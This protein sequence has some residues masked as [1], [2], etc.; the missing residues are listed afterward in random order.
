MSYRRKEMKNF[1]KERVIY[2]FLLVML[3]TLPLKT[4]SVVAQTSEQ[5]SSTEKTTTSIQN[6]NSII[7]NSD[8]EPTNSMESSAK[9]GADSSETELSIHQ[10]K[11]IQLK[12]NQELTSEMIED[13]VTI[14][15][16]LKDSTLEFLPEETLF[17]TTG[18][19]TV[20]IKIIEKYGEEENEIES[21][22]TISVE[23][24]P[25]IIAE[26]NPQDLI[27]GSD[28]SMWDISDFV[29]WVRIDG[30]E[31][32]KN[33]YIVDLVNIPQTD[34]VYK[35][36]IKVKVSDKSRARTILVDVPINIVWG[37][38]IVYQT[39]TTVYEA[40]RTAGA[41]TL[42]TLGKPVVT[43]AIGVTGS[44]DVSSVYT[45][46]DPLLQKLFYTF[47][48]FDLSNTQ[49]FL[50]T[51]ETK[52]TKHVEAFG[53]D[54]IKDNLNLWGINRKQDVHY[55]DVVRAW[56]VFPNWNY[57]YQNDKKTLYN[58]GQNSI[59]YEI[60]PK[61]YKPLKI[62]F[63]STKKQKISIGA[64][65]R[66][67]IDNI[68]KSID[69][70]DGVTARF[71]KLPSRAKI[72]DAEGVIRVSQKLS[73]G[74]AIEYDYIVPFEIV[75]DQMTVK[76]KDDAQFILGQY[77]NNFDYK[78]FIQEVKV[79][80]KTLNRDEYNTQ[81]LSKIDNEMLY[82]GKTGVRL[83][84]SSAQSNNVVEN[85]ILVNVNW[86]QSI[87]FGGIEIPNLP[88][89]RT[90][91]VYT[92]QLEE[93][94]QIVATPGNREGLDSQIHYYFTNEDYYKV[95]YFN[96]RTSRKIKDTDKGDKSV[97][98]QGQQYPREPVNQWGRVDVNYG[99]IIRSFAA[100]KDRHWVYEGDEQKQSFARKNNDYVYYEITKQGYSLLEIN[101]LNTKKVKV[102]VNSSKEYL[103]SIK[104]SFFT[105]LDSNKINVMGFSKYPDTSKPTSSGT[106]EVS[107]KLTTGKTITYSYEVTIGTTFTIREQ[108]VDEKNNPL[109]KEKIT[110]L[111]STDAYQ[112]KP[113]K[114]LDNNGTIY[115]YFG[116]SYT[117][118]SNSQQETIVGMPN[119]TFRSNTKIKYFYRNT[120]K[121]INV[122]LPTDLVFGTYN[123]PKKVTAKNYQI[124]NNSEELK[125]NVIF[126]KFEK[127]HSNVKLLSNT[128]KEPNKEEN[129][130]KLNLLIDNQ[131][132]IKGLNEA[133]QSQ[134]IKELAPQSATNISI[135]GQYYGKMSEKNI[136]EYK[137]K[138]KFKAL[139]D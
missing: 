2:I 8:L 122:T 61:G 118:D 79:G 27:V 103:D 85:T 3:L 92:L 36:I 46:Y 120:D 70:P 93:K 32:N 113:D 109:S 41:Y 52:G 39:N 25:E 51:E 133:T 18:D 128:E 43:S 119:Q 117:N 80:N 124:R 83:R 47:N 56:H 4:R 130:A 29:K 44:L 58:Q 116:Y 55:G 64:S 16:K 38:S 10:E 63:A 89:W 6:S 87:A 111:D 68:G 71:I 115:K 77:T 7:K 95:D 88:A 98:A 49:N 13:A 99:D 76:F 129:S 54:Q 62:N 82:I 15:N 20:N 57:L 53:K 114:F 28:S 48:W 24:A 50:M 37:D 1:Y 19:K 135:D 72:G 60:T 69:L 100:E 21:P 102:P 132:A 12:V 97:T 23:K 11:A 107:E 31:V 84:V 125:T 94:P 86:G 73:T 123:S 75:K 105:N 65:D 17:S 91:G 131:P 139:A 121:L 106:L 66:E 110:V 5:D 78:N 108:A 134:E 45:G 42:H 14:N 101:R 96:M 26:Q 137:T 74:K 104:A 81:L 40:H 33:E 67:I 30:K 35:Q 9:R 90:A 126:E 112:P 127:V 22:I 59:Y 136:V 34:R 138:L